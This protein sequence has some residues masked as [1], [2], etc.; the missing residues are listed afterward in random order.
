MIN[1]ALGFWQIGIWAWHTVGKPTCLNRGSIG[2]MSWKRSVALTQYD[3][4][5]SCFLEREG[6][7][8][9]RQELASRLRGL[10]PGPPP[11]RFAS[12]EGL[13]HLDIFVWVMVNLEPPLLGLD[14]LGF[15]VP[16]RV[17]EEISPTHFFLPY[18]LAN[19]PS[20][21]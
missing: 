21:L 11:V 4:R 3:A 5:N 15:L 18:G 13:G 8:N 17:D 7:E 9:T 2:I 19:G 1:P 16:A 6:L 10:V 12:V 20:D 14:N